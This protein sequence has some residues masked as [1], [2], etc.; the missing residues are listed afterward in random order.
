MFKKLVLPTDVLKIDRKVCSHVTAALF[1]EAKRREPPKCPCED[2]DE[3]GG[4]HAQCNKPVTGRQTLCDA[5]HVRSLEESKAES[6]AG[7]GAGVSRGQ[8]FRL[9]K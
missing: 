4:H 5:T 9:G 3:P 1:T 6:R 8:G 2:M 7:R